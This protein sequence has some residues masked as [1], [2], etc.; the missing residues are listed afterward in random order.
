VFDTVGGETLERS[1]GVL[2][3]SGSLVTIAASSEGANDLRTHAAFFIVKADR[4]QLGTIACL[5]DEEHIR[6]VVDAVFSLAAARRAYERRAAQ[7]KVVLGVGELTVRPGRHFI[8]TG[9]SAFSRP[10]RCTSPAAM[11]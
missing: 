4:E 11:G 9:C 6:P 2:K 3:P 10:A 7:G 8:C 1:W 5:I